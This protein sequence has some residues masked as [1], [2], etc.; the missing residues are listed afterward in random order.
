M[1]LA[2]FGNDNAVVGDK[3][4]AGVAATGGTADLESAANDVAFCG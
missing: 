4:V 2:S 3:D 1:R